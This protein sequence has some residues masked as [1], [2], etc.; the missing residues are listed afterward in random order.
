MAVFTRCHSSK[1]GKEMAHKSLALQ[2]P[3]AAADFLINKIPAEFERL[4]LSVTFYSDEYV[5]PVTPAAGTAT[6]TATDDGFNFG[7]VT[8]GAIDVT[9]PVYDRPSAVGRFESV[10]ATLAGVTGATHF[11]I[12]VNLYN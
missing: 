6:I 1:K 7:T 9:D 3:V 5:T 8:N 12:I 4:Y 2:A 11:R 10:K